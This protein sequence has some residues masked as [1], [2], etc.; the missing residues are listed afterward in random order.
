MYFKNSIAYAIIITIVIITVGK[1]FT[2][3]NSFKAVDNSTLEDRIKPL[4]QVHVQGDAI[5]VAPIKTAAKKP[6]KKSKSGA[7]VYTQSCAACHSIGV[8]GAPKMG[9]KD[10]WTSRLKGGI[11]A[12]VKTAITGKGAMPPKGTCGTCSEAELK[13]AIEHMTK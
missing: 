3:L 13:A 4:G 5:K 11:D 6:A 2:N 9:N 1:I 12:L 8:A 7:D 10:D